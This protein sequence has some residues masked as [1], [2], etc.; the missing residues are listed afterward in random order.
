MKA[1]R[2]AWAAKVLRRPDFLAVVL[3][4]DVASQKIIKKLLS[5]RL[6]NKEWKAAIALVLVDACWLAP[7]F[8]SG[9]LFVQDM[10]RLDL[11]MSQVLVDEHMAPLPSAVQ[12]ADKMRKLAYFTDRMCLHLYDATTLFRALMQLF[13]FLE[14][15]AFRD[16]ILTNVAV[17]VGAAMQV[18]E[19]NVGV[20][21]GACLVLGRLPH[22]HMTASEFQA[23]GL[24]AKLVRVM[25][26]FGHCK[27]VTLI[28]PASFACMS[29]HILP[30]H[31]FH[32]CVCSLSLS[33]SVM[34][35]F[36][37]SLSLHVNMC[38]CVLL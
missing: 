30:I 36:S 6:V 22:V 15:D 20:Q 26:R 10:A 17:V 19:F 23:T 32:A 21:D 27:Y 31:N 7:I 28:C 11:E 25:R 38:V 24:I 18:H 12:I 14:H 2:Y 16:Q 8:A 29:T 3:R 9:C 37:L 1:E 13:E 35:S 34:L 33:F 5:R 4:C